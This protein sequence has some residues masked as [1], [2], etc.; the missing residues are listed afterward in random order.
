MSLK[1]LRPICVGLGVLSSHMTFLEK[2]EDREMVC[3]GKETRRREGGERRRRGEREGEGREKEGGG[4]GEKKEGGGGGASTNLQYFRHILVSSSI[5]SS[6]V[7]IF[8][9]P[10]FSPFPLSEDGK[11]GC[12]GKQEDWGIE[13]KKC[14]SMGLNMQMPIL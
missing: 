11:R 9:S 7:L 1:W 8:F 12:E 3:V 4:G 6:D 10:F 5:L 2:K 13:E 14:P